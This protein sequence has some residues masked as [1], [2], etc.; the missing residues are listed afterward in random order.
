M[1]EAASLS[2]ED[3]GSVRLSRDRLVLLARLGV[4]S[5]F[6]LVWQA[7]CSA[8]V[9]PQIL[10]TPLA[11]LRATGRLLQDPS[12]VAAIGATLL[13]LASAFLIALVAG[14][15]IGYA[16]SLG[17]RTERIGMPILLMFYALPQ[18]TI[19]PLFVLYFGLGIAGKIAFGVSHGLFPV[20]L[21]AHA[22]MRRRNAQYDRWA[23]SLGASRWQRFR[24]LSLP[25]LL[26]ALCTG[27]RL[28]MAMTLLGVLLAE[29]YVSSLGIGFYVQIY[30]NALQSDAL[31]S[32]VFMLA[33]IAILLNSLVGMMERRMRRFET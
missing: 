28:A 33:L 7:A 23:T 22:G 20:A 25:Q 3:G 6:L 10:P 32:L 18:I 11:V 21:G 29:L 24:R 12:L 26:P 1:T 2:A 16:L 19:L 31:F 14:G 13:E 15:L 17:L 27:M 5:V 4:I 8:G 9:S 30:T